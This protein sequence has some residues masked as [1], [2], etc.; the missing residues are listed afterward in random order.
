[1]LVFSRIY[2][3]NSLLDY[4]SSSGYVHALDRVALVKKSVNLCTSE[5][6]SI[7]RYFLSVQNV[8]VEDCLYSNR[9]NTVAFVNRF[10]RMGDNTMR[11]RAVFPITA[12]PLSDSYSCKAVL[13]N[14]FEYTSE[15]VW[16]IQRRGRQ[17]C[18]GVWRNIPLRLK[19]GLINVSLVIEKR[20]AS[21]QKR[22]I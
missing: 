11:C 19:I 7:I 10:H 20:S 15:V 5:K 18:A 1:M 4:L 9:R 14:S 2:S 22:L 8:I 16:K 6:Y 17:R 12:G 13:F 3:A 21:R